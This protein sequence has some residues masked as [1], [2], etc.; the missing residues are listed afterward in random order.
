MKF[1]KEFPEPPGCNGLLIPTALKGK[2]L[3]IFL[4]HLECAFVMDVA[5]YERQLPHVRLIGYGLWHQEATRLQC[6]EVPNAIRNAKVSEA[7]ANANLCLTWK[8]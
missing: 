3:G 2:H 6:A 7:L 5:N 8:G 1:P 4:G